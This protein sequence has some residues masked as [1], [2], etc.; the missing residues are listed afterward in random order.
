MG[1]RENFTAG[2]VAEF[3]CP[4][5]KQ[6]AIYW[7][8]KQPGLGLRVTASGARSY[9]FQ[10]WL[11]AGA[12]RVT[13]GR[14]EVWPLESVWTL[15]KAKGKRIEVQR[16]ARQEAARLKALV[17][18]GINPA[19]QRREQEEAKATARVQAVTEE[20]RQALTVGEVW[21]AYMVERRTHWGERHYLDNLRIVQPSGKPSKRRGD[22]SKARIA[23]PL[24]VFMPLPLAQLDAA[25]IEAWAAR[26]GQTRPTSARLA[27][28]LL[29]AFLTWCAEHPQYAGIV[30]TPNPAKTKRTREALGKPGKKSDV[31]TREQLPTWFAHVRQIQN[32]AIAAALQVM[33]L[34]GARP[35]EVLSLRWE[36]MNTQWHSITIRDKVEGERMIPLT[37]YV[38]Q[39]LAALP[40]R[41][42]W[43]FSSPSSASGQLSRPQAPHASACKAAGLDNLTLH[44]LRRSFSTLTEWLEIPAGPVAQIMG[45]KP[46]ATAERHYKVRPLDLLRVH[47]ER[48]EAWLLEQAGIE[49]QA[50]QALPTLRRVQ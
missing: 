13:I 23:A 35:G 1:K 46:S 19:E 45:H 11:G 6:Q 37:P 34:T 49:F 24:A 2:R 14:P 10:G 29:R 36:D 8:A 43:V 38:A 26:E 22:R 41:N 42:A 7:D 32:P 17:D 3:T 33:L 39:L 5:G 28:R 16:G 48:I 20:Q 40:R 47:H 4:A 15:D 25:R 44:G 50:A 30:Q 27:W 18:G 31:L 9:V 12:V 21:T